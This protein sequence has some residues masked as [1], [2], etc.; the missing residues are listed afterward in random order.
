MP[1]EAL[2]AI[3]GKPISEEPA[4]EVDSGDALMKAAQNAVDA[5]KGGEKK[6]AAAALLSLVQMAALED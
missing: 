2:K 4:K 3:M 5:I 6:D 1:S